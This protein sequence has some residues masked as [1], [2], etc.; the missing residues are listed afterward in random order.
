MCKRKNP[1]NE[2]KVPL[3]TKGEM[4]PGYGR[5]W[6]NAGDLSKNM[7]CNKSGLL[8]GARK[9]GAMRKNIVANHGCYQLVEFYQMRYADDL[10]S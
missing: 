9:G 8:Q 2:Q 4:R 6:T 3:L 1:G 5:A 7:Y 10:R